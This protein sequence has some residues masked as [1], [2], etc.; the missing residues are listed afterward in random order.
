MEVTFFVKTGTQHP[1]INKLLRSADLAYGAVVPDGSGF[2]VSVEWK[3]GEIVNAQRIAKA[4]Q[5]LRLA[6]E[7]QGFCVLSVERAEK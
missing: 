5:T 1:L 6:L 4:Q 7:A 2:E 3:K